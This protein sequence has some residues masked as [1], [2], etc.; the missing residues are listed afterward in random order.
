MKQGRGL[1]IVPGSSPG[2]L[3]STLR[4][5][6]PQGACCRSP[7]LPAIDPCNLFMHSHPLPPCGHQIKRWLNW[8]ELIKTPRNYGLSTGLVVQINVCS[9]RQASWPC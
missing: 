9:N 2:D 3:F 1:A 8:H 5:E 6:A 7:I 4:S